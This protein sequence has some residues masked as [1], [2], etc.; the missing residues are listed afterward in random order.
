ML[1]LRNNFDLYVHLLTI[2]ESAR[3]AEYDRLRPSL[4]FKVKSFGFLMKKGSEVH[5]VE[6][7]RREEQNPQS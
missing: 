3:Q 2:E 5:A 6:S 7:K 4:S 1:E